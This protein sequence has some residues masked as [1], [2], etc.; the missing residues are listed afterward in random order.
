MKNKTFHITFVD[1]EV[2]A[3]KINEEY[4]INTT[5]NINTS[6]SQI[7]EKIIHFNIEDLDYIKKFSKIETEFNDINDKM[8]DL[9]EIADSLNNKLRKGILDVNTYHRNIQSSYMDLKVKVLSKKVE[10]IETKFSEEMQS[11][12]TQTQEITNNTFFNIASVFLGVS[13]VS[14]M[15]AGIQYVDKNYFLL[16]FLTVGWVALLVLSL[17]SILI[18]RFNRKSIGLL[19][20][21]ALYTF[22]VFSFGWKTLDI[23]KEENSNKCVVNQNEKKNDKKIESDKE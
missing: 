8:T 13:L 14:S 15:V 22:I 4:F 10:N 9:L 12:I 16:Y 2:E 21:L 23:I 3:Q 18:R 1:G 20:V 5:K 6:L 17:S 11:Q 7:K 19:V